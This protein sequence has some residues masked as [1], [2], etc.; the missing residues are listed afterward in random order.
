MQS[1]AAVHDMRLS[2][3]L[4]HGCCHKLDALTLHSPRRTCSSTR[5][6]DT[7]S[8]FNGRHAALGTSHEETH[9]GLHGHRRSQP[10]LVLHDGRSPR[11]QPVGLAQG[12]CGRLAISSLSK[13]VE[14]SKNGEKS[15]K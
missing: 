15:G 7:A 6:H 8:V 4:E 5:S 2:D 13:P 14:H 12:R 3:R 10:A 9:G 11:Q 1:S